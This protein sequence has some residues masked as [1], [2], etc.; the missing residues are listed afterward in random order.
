[1]RNTANPVPDAFLQLSP[2]IYVGSGIDLIGF[3][4]LFKR[5]QFRLIRVGV[6]RPPFAVS[7]SPLPSPSLPHGRVLSG[8]GVTTA[9]G[10]PDA[11]L[12]VV[13]Y[14]GM[15]CGPHCATARSMIRARLS[16]TP[17]VTAAR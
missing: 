15:N 14:P 10:D 9:D 4:L 3:S 6:R 16:L 1:M 13:I 17:S 5:H 7:T 2:Y 11:K 12:F 8:Q